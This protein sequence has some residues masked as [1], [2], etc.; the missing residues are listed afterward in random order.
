M[1]DSFKD[2]L[3]LSTMTLATANSSGEAHAAP[4]YF[5]ALQS[6]TL[7]LELYFFSAPDSRHTQDLATNSHAA[8]AIYPETTG[9]EDIRGLQ[10]EGSVRLLPEGIEWDAAWQVYLAKFPFTSTMKEIIAQN[11]FYAFH[12][13]WVR[14]I[15]N[16]LGFGYKQ[17]W[18]LDGRA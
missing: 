17:E 6:S 12:A 11:A 8:A 13:S 2:L 4:V 10:L 9:W 18:T 5:A 3:A 14:L 15:D 16:R 1:D 7:S